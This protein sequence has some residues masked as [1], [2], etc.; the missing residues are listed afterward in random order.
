MHTPG[1]PKQ[2]VAQTVHCYFHGNVS[3][4]VRVR[5]AS[6]S[7]ISAGCVEF[8]VF[9]CIYE[10]LSKWKVTCLLFVLCSFFSFFSL[11]DFTT[12]SVLMM[13][14]WNCPMLGTL[15][16]WWLMGGVDPSIMKKAFV[17]LACYITSSKAYYS[18]FSLSYHW[19]LLINQIPPSTEFSC[20]C[21]NCNIFSW[22]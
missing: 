9:R 6:T 22:T 4:C 1:S 2:A 11:F 20:L 7:N 17:C 10:T 16:K 12:M 15:A 14:Q 3:F 5:S 21:I 19:F 8:T 18:S 13:C